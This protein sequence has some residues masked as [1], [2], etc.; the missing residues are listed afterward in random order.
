MHLVT[1]EIIQIVQDFEEP[2]A[3]VRVK[4]ARMTVSITLIPDAQ[5]GEKV[6]IE[7]GVAISK[8]NERE[9]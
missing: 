3:I 2:R 1:G 7:S 4:G 8:I 9:E 6:L 5:P